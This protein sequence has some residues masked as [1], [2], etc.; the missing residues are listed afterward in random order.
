MS[1]LYESARRSL[2]LISEVMSDFFVFKLTYVIFDHLRTDRQDIKT[3]NVFTY[4]DLAR[5]RGVQRPCRY[6]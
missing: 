4:L 6:Y 2:T 3:Y 1:A 5:V